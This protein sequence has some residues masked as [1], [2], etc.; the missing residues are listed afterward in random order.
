MKPIKAISDFLD[1]WT[2]SVAT[3]IIAGVDRAMPPRVVRVTE[4]GG[5]LF[6]EPGDAKPAIKV[7]SGSLESNGEL[8]SLLRGAKIEVMLDPK[9]FV[10]RPVEV[11]ARAAGFLEGIVR[12]QIDRLTPWSASEALFGCSP[13][14]ASGSET[15]TTIVAVTTR[16]AIEKYLGPLSVFHPAAISI[17]TQPAEPQIGR[18]KVFEQ[19]FRQYLGAAQLNRGLKAAFG[20]TGVLALLAVVSALSLSSYLGAQ[21][22]EINNEIS[23][24]RAAIRA[25]TSAGDRSP[26]AMLR[27][28]KL[29]TTP[30]VLVLDGL[31]KVLPDNTYVTELHL[32]ENKVQIVGISTD[33]SSLIPL[34]EQSTTFKSATFFAPTTSSASDR[35]ERFHIEAEI[36][37]TPGGKP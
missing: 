30:L 25:N 29:E 11:P 8:E 19:N 15:I 35:N 33:A 14:L 31:T 4:Q 6:I 21:Q 5:D 10:L 13:P 36:Q 9:H 12:A 17:W 24:R 2:G 16:R 18:L 23:Q 20:L 37:T 1:P 28:R 32:A 3:A 26:L 27:R 34:I 7:S 22:E